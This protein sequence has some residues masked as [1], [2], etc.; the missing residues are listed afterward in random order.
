MMFDFIRISKEDW[1]EKYAKSARMSVFGEDLDPSVERIDFGYLVADSAKK[2]LRIYSTFY[3]MDNESV[4][5]TF[6]GAFPPSRGIGNTPAAF[7][8][9][10]AHL[11]TL[12]YKSV[13][14]HCKNTN[15][16]MIKLGA[17][18]GAL[19]VGISTTPRAVLLE[20]TVNL[21]KESH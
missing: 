9:L 7:G 3:E 13:H 6:G 5:L 11:G 8:A 12:G 14:W 1:A 20:H 2:E 18:V 21:K 10:L 19:I 16:P 15:G 4:Y 17:R